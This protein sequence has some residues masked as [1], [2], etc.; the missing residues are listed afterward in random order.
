M[1]LNGKYSFE[2]VSICKLRSPAAIFVVREESFGP[3][4]PV[5]PNSNVALS[6]RVKKFF[7]MSEINQL[8]SFASGESR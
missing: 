7:K 2:Q 1:L 6:L 4:I 5:S 3:E 8:I